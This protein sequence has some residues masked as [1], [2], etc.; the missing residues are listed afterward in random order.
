M[1]RQGWL[2]LKGDAL[3]R[4]EATSMS[5]DEGCAAGPCSLHRVG[6]VVNRGENQWGMQGMGCCLFLTWWGR[7]GGVQR[8]WVISH[9]E[10]NVACGKLGRKAFFFIIIFKMT[11]LS[12]EV[13]WCCSAL[14]FS[15]LVPF[16]FSWIT[17][18]SAVFSL[19]ERSSL[20]W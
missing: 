13:S 6:A 10:E 19:W 14:I 17:C 3:G 9:L 8:P 4:G 16:Y 18:C 11:S 1:E 12:S 15:F 2:T 5:E 7:L 20:W